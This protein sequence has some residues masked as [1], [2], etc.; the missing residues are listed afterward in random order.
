MGPFIS[1]NIVVM[2]FF[3]D[4][5]TQNFFFT[6]QCVSSLWIVFLTRVCSGKPM[7]N[8]F[9]KIFLTKTCFSIHIAYSSVIFTW[10]TFLSYQIKFKPEKTVWFGYHFD[11][12]QNKYF[13]NKP[14]PNNTAFT[15]MKKIPFLYWMTFEECL[16]L[17]H[18]SEFKPQ[19]C[20]YVHF[21]M[22]WTTLNA[23][24]LLNVELCHYRYSTGMALVL[25]NGNGTIQRWY[26]I[27]ER[28]KEKSCK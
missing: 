1:Q 22:V 25:N 7:F 17:W 14:I 27:K 3:T 10:F 11:Y 4:C 20:Y 12:P 2:I 8:L 5:C 24:S 23:L 13:Y 19:S 15:F 9:V 28:K 18:C 6:R 16:K 26:A 21:W